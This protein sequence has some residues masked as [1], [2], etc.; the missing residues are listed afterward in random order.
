MYL[1]LLGLALLALKLLDVDPVAGW[2]WWV[3]LTP[4]GLAALWWWW[5]DTT[6]YTRRKAME[7][8]EQRKRARL[9][10]QRDQLGLKRRR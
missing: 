2:A 4:F 1:L 8:E 3:V 9:N 5:A 7:R 6:G 10:K